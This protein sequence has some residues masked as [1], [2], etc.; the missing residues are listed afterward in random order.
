MKIRFYVL[1]AIII[2]ICFAAVHNAQHS[3]SEDKIHAAIA[4]SVGPIGYQ[5]T[6]KRADSDDEVIKLE[7]RDSETYGP[8][9]R[10]LFRLRSLKPWKNY[11]ST[12]FRY[13]LIRETYESQAQA[14]KRVA[15]Y[16]EGYSERLETEMMSR[17]MISKTI[18]RVDA[19]RRGTTVYLLVTDGLYTAD[20]DKSQRKILDTLI[21]AGNT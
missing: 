16:K 10:M 9:S 7:Y 12:Y 4:Q 15:E 5:V 14:E 20:D 21:K 2:L 3:S 1:A 11:A 18:I 17:H 6:E 8:S 13:W 19:R